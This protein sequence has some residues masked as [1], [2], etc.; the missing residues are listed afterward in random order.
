MWAGVREQVGGGFLPLDGLLPSLW[1]LSTRTCVLNAKYAQLLKMQ[2]KSRLL[3]KENEPKQKKNQ[4]APWTPRA[5]PTAQW[6]RAASPQVG[7]AL[8][9]MLRNARCVLQQ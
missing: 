4:Q 6:G 2:E 5:C 9:K 1:A 3:Q 8:L 7:R